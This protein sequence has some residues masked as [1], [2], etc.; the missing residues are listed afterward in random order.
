MLPTATATISASHAQSAICELGPR[1][2]A[3]TEK[4]TAAKLKIIDVI[5]TALISN[6]AL[7]P[8]EFLAKMVTP[9]AQTETTQLSMRVDVLFKN[10]LLDTMSDLMKIPGV[11]EGLLMISMYTGDA[12]AHAKMIKEAALPIIKDLVTDLDT[13]LPGIIDEA[14]SSGMDSPAL[15]KQFGLD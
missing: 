12:K 3:F 11:L 9:A 10:V 4:T 1:A 2:K 14:T 13:K 7:L 5:L 8:N 6:S 15:L